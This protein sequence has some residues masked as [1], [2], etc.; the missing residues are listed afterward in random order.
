MTIKEFINLIDAYERRSFKLH[1]GL[2]GKK[3]F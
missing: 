1:P 2:S 3:G